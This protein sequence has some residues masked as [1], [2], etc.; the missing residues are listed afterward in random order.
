L[1]YEGKYIIGPSAVQ[2]W[3][4][5][6]LIISFNACSWYTWYSHI[7]SGKQI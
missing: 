6:L 2:H 3:I 5:Y 4:E 7:K 1:D